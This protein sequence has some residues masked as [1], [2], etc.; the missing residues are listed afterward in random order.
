MCVFHTFSLAPKIDAEGAKTISFHIWDYHEPPS[1]PAA[2]KSSGKREASNKSHGKGE[3]GKGATSSLPGKIP[4]TWVGY[5]A[6]PLSVL[7]A[8]RGRV[9]C[10]FPLKKIVSFSIILCFSYS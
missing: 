7:T 10:T 3:S 2:S 1:T 4:P 6:V 5:T 8:K 9:D